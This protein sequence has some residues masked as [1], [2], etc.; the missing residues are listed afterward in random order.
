MA[1]LAG[2]VGDEYS[3]SCCKI[4]LYVVLG[5]LGGGGFASL[6]LS[7]EKKFL[8]N[9]S[10]KI[11]IGDLLFFVV[12]LFGW[13]SWS[14]LGATCSNSRLALLMSLVSVVGEEDNSR[15]LFLFMAV[16]EPTGGSRSAVGLV[17]F[18]GKAEAKVLVAC[19]S[20]FAPISGPVVREEESGV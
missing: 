15:L 8:N 3:G 6:S 11:L 9:S 14:N 13:A 19:I 10:D 17:V 2:L 7:C 18:L 20:M 1:S 16:F 4:W 5:A 12:L